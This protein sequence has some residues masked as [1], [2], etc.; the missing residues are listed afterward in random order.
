MNRKTGNSRSSARVMATRRAVLCALALAVVAGAAGGLANSPTAI[1]DVA[2]LGDVDD[3][4]ASLEK[5]KFVKLYRAQKSSPNRNHMCLER[6]E[7]KHVDG[8]VSRERTASRSKRVLLTRSRAKKM[9]TTT[10]VVSRRL[11]TVK[12]VRCGTIGLEPRRPRFAADCLAV[13]HRVPRRIRRHRRRLPVII[14]IQCRGAARGARGL[15]HIPTTTSVDRGPI[16]TE[17]QASSGAGTDLEVIGRRAAASRIRT[18]PT[19][20]PRER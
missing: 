7:V 11:Q 3:M 18:T 8:K 13:A 19:N 4:P 17:T 12:S 1:L 5:V 6:I 2:A 15:A 14:V 9:A 10:V 16:S 20:S